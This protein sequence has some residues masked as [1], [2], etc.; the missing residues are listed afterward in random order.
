V[1]FRLTCSLLCKTRPSL[2]SRAAVCMQTRIIDPPDHLPS[3]TLPR[4]AKLRQHHEAIVWQQAQAAAAA[5]ERPL[6]AQQ[7]DT[8][9]SEEDETASQGSFSSSEAASFTS[10]FSARSTGAIST[11]GSP[12]TSMALEGSNGRQAGNG[13][14]PPS[15]ASAR[16]STSWGRAS[17]LQRSATSRG[18][19]NLALRS[20]SPGREI[21]THLRVGWGAG[22]R[23]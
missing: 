16:T 22:R 14:V 17:G 9:S 20:S 12:T 7:E 1:F 3:S 18:A 2:L 6:A 21:S 4:R 5:A 15:N 11:A 19:G 13:A 23:T 10:S 8:G